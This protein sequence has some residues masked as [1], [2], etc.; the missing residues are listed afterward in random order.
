[1]SRLI[2]GAVLAAIAFTARPALAQQPSLEILVAKLS[3]RTDATYIQIEIIA[4]RPIAI[5]FV[6]LRCQV[7]DASNTS[8][9]TFQKDYSS[10]DPRRYFTIVQNYY[11]RPEMS[12]RYIDNAD[13]VSCWFATKA[14]PL[15]KA[16]PADI[17]VEM[18]STHT[19]RVTNR[20]PFTLSAKTLVCSGTDKSG[21]ASTAT[22]E[23]NNRLGLGHQPNY[24]ND[25]ELPDRRLAGR[26]SCAVTAT[27]VMEA[28][29]LP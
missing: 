20:S 27:K 21:D 25:A 1:M 8:L 15:P 19:V 23:M 26:I 4:R 11:W 9:G 12:V 16:I 14:D 29:D 3:Q 2:I 7:F 5:P 22:Y 24:T 6:R 13:H 18:I 28:P 17:D 10:G